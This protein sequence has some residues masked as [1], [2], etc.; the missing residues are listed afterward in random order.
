MGVQLIVLRQ[1][2]FTWRVIITTFT[3]TPT[4][5]LLLCITFEEIDNNNL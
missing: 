2:N 1:R 3:R 5:L 4:L